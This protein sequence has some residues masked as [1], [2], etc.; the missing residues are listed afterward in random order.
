VIDFYELF[1]F[2]SRATFTYINVIYLN[3]IFLYEIFFKIYFLKFYNTILITTISSEIKKMVF[4]LFSMEKLFTITQTN[5][6][7][8]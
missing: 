4:L 2:F 7:K 3:S 8:K 5:P 6:D 1:R